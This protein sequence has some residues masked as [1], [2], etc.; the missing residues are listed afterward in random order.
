MKIPEK[1]DTQGAL[2]VIEETNALN[3][4]KIQYALSNYFK[5][6]DV[7]YEERKEVFLETPESLQ[8]HLGQFLK[9]PK[10]DSKYTKDLY[11]DTLYL[12]RGDHFNILEAYDLD[13]EVF[14][15]LLEDFINAGIHSF[16]FDW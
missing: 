9:T 10:Y 11:V 1:Y 12:D 13:D 4:T 15:V 8:T 16:T 2:A 14:E 7:P 3:I 6:Q 5:D